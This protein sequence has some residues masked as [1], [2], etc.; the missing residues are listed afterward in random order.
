L[1]NRDIA[2]YGNTEGINPIYGKTCIECYRKFDPDYFHVMTPIVRG[3]NDF[4]DQR[5]VI[6]QVFQGWALNRVIDLYNRYATGRVLEPAT[7]R[8]LWFLEKRR[9]QNKLVP[10]TRSD[11][12]VIDYP[13]EPGGRAP[14]VAVQ[15]ARP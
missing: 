4:Q 5:S 1:C 7:G 10:R 6:T 8:A 14:V 11:G 12:F 15:V 3:P 13:F 9:P 2:L